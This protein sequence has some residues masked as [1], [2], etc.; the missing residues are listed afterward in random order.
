MILQFYCLFVVYRVIHLFDKPH[1]NFLRPLFPIYTISHFFG[2]SDIA[3]NLGGHC[4]G[5]RVRLTISTQLKIS[6][7]SR[8]IKS[9]LFVRIECQIANI[10]KLES[11][12]RTEIIYIY[13]RFYKIFGS[14]YS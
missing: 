4:K 12:Y 14:V 7:E 11:Y 6:A 9:S 8:F 10:T 1:D 3:M 2:H 5:G 13:S